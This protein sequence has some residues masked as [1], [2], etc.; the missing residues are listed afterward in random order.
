MSTDAVHD[1]DAIGDDL[2]VWSVDDLSLI[3]I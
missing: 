2:E 1:S 3:H